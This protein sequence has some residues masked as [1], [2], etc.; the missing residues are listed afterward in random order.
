[1][2][3]LLGILMFGSVTI[4]PTLTTISCS[5]TIT[6]TIKTSFNDGTQVEK[7]VWKDNRYQ[8]D[9]QSSNIQDITNSLNGT[10]NAY[11]KTVTDV[12]NLF[13]RNIQE[14]RN[15]KESY[16]LFRGKA[17]DTS[18]VG[19]YTG[20]NSQR[21][22]ISQQDFYKKLD[23]SHTHISS[24]KGLLQLRE[25]VNDNKNKTAVDSWKNSLKIDADEVK[26]WSDEFTKNLD[27]IVNSS[28]DNKIKDIKLVSKV[29]KTSSSFATFEQD[30][31]TAPT[32]DKGNIELKNDNNGKVVGD[33]K[34]LKDHNPYVFG[35][36]PVNDPFGMNV[37]GEN[38]DP[39]ISKLKPTINY[40]T[41]KLTKKD[42]SYINLSNNGNNN[43]QFVYNI[44][45]K[46]ELSSAHNFYYM[47]PKEET[48][49]LKITHSIE[50]KNFTFYV[51]FG[52][53]RKIYT[54]IVEAYTPKD[55]NSADKR[56]S[57]V[58]WT[59]NSYRFSD[60]F[61]KGNSSPYRFKDISLKISDK[62]FTTNSGSVN[63]K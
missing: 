61:S 42:D 36:S 49:E 9:G 54:P 50:N 41:E 17:E 46:W 3:K 34:N 25:F 8:S 18:V 59:F 31:K 22:K 11:S 27:N 29:S 39:D 15:L 60:D 16:D 30:V 40:S 10:T 62:S 14:V 56:Y 43:N 37:I 55:S 48:L 63:G 20:A 58:G 5:T 13:T 19:Y 44:N 47:S 33:I 1:M 53:L 57:F 12:L 2:K 32:T 23:D 51:Q 21:Q 52:G 35:T 4:F 26:K 28:T 6:H 24:L 38:K 7:F 45:Q